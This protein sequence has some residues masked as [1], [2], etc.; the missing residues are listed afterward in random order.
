MALHAQALSL[1]H[2][3]PVRPNFCSDVGS[4]YIFA[5]DHLFCKELNIWSSTQ[6][7]VKKG[8]KF[9]RKREIGAN[10]CQTADFHSNFKPNELC[11]QNTVSNYDYILEH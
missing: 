8:R 3:L 11:L 10:L 1:L 2:G 6:S 7:H 9:T 4:Q 5:E